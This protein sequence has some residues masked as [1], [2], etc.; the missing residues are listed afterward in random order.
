MLNFFM[1]LDALTRIASSRHRGMI[2]RVWRGQGQALAPNARNKG[3]MR[4][5]PPVLPFKQIGLEQSFFLEQRFGEL[6]GGGRPRLHGARG[7]VEQPVL[8]HVFI[9]RFLGETT[10]NVSTVDHVLLIE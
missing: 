7:H 5:S 9:K 8:G 4:A 6:L 10:H 2:R 1:M 3:E